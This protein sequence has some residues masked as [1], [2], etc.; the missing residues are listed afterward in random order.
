MCNEMCGERVGSIDGLHLQVIEEFEVAGGL[1]GPLD[2]LAE[3]HSAGSPIG[4]VCAVHSVKG[5]CGFGYAAH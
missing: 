1:R 5:A 3:G 4:P 2:S